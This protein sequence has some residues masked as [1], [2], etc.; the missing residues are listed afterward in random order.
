MKKRYN[1]SV[2]LKFLLDKSKE[3]VKSKLGTESASSHNRILYFKKMLELL[4]ESNLSKESLKYYDMYNKEFLKRMKCFDYVRPLLDFCKDN[5]IKVCICTDM[6]C[7][8]QMKKLKRLGLSNKFKYVI[9]SEEVGCEKPDEKIYNSI[10]I[11]VGDF[12]PQHY[13]FIGDSE[14]KDVNGPKQIG[15]KSINVKELFNI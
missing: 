13:I 9:T 8:I 3:L 2:D 6:V 15:M 4:G 14:E 12:D 5:Q 1:C 10:L 7:E 11:A